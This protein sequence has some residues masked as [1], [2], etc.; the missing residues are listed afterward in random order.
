MIGPNGAVIE[1]WRPVGEARV[2]T[3]DGLDLTPGVVYAIEVRALRAAQ[4]S[5]EAEPTGGALSD[6]VLVIN[7]GPPEVTVTLDR[8]FVD[9]H[10]EPVTVTV[11]AHDDD[12]LAGW[13]LD[14]VSLDGVLVRRL[15][16][17]PLAQA[18]FHG[19]RRWE[20]LDGAKSEVPPGTYRIV[21]RATDRA[22][23]EGRDEKRVEVCDG[24]CP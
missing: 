7:E 3:V 21:A 2:V 6:G 14:V 22:R 19:E 13:S 1:D 9:P 11:D 24:A 20:G 10:G 17:E 16:G 18:D 23:N 12:L 8:A 4:G 5:D 15:A